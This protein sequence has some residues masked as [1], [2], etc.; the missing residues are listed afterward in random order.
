MRFYN[1]TRLAEKLLK[2]GYLTG[3]EYA[4]FRLLIVHG[5][6]FEGDEGYV[7]PDNKINFFYKPPFGQFKD[8]NEIYPEFKKRLEGLLFRLQQL[9]LINVT[10]SINV[11]TG[12]LHKYGAVFTDVTI[13]KENIPTEDL[14]EEKQLFVE[15]IK[16]E[17]PENPDFS[18]SILKWLNEGEKHEIL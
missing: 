15:H 8:Y 6:T 4:L 2:N 7:L 11:I 9:N 10:C 16:I 14:G 3:D 5:G 1:V 12:T 18:E 17:V 13:K